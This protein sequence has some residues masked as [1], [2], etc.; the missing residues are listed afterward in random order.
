MSG[1]VGPVTRLIFMVV[2]LWV[3]VACGEEVPE[4]GFSFDLDSLDESDLFI[5]SADVTSLFIGDLWGP[6]ECPESFGQL[7]VEMPPNFP[8]KT[9]EFAC[10]RIVEPSE[11]SK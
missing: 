5:G 9:A 7:I 11:A 6:E 10:G 2:L 3:G 4:G 8:Y 1:A